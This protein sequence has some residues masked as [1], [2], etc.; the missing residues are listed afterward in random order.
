MNPAARLSSAAIALALSP[1]GAVAQE[2]S[3]SFA[4]TALTIS[5]EHVCAFQARAPFDAELR[6]FVV[7]LS[8]A[9]VDTEAAVEALDPHIH[10]VNQPAVRDTNYVSV[11]V[12]PNGQV[13]MNAMQRE[14][15]VQYVD[16]T[17][18]QLEAEITVSSEEEIA[19]RVH[20][21]KPVELPSGESYT[22]DLSFSTP[23]TRPPVGKPLGDGGGEPGVA[24]RALAEAARAEH[25]PGMRP[26][27][28]ADYFEDT[29]CY[30]E[31]DTP[32]D[33]EA[34][35]CALRGL[36]D[37]L[38][39]S[40]QAFEIVAGEDRGETAVLEVKQIY[41]PGFEVLNLAKMRRGPSGWVLEHSISV[42]PY[43]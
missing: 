40:D 31:S 8:E 34:L 6:G 20:T 5:P 41:E 24:L 22:V 10:A 23:V 21:E 13:A 25:W 32:S 35:A 26:R 29:Y 7:L 11:Y 9:A 33:A 36:P 27:L 39:R 30:F 43:R 1:F 18:M 38:T 12:W 19:G 42:G 4:A 14:G 17:T 37:W 28:P 3:G 2:V 16:N 15:G